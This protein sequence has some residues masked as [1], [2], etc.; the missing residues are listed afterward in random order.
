MGAS[1]LA[2]VL[3]RSVRLDGRDIILLDTG[4][5]DLNSSIYDDWSM[6]ACSVAGEFQSAALFDACTICI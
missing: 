2:A 3:D 4:A 5:A 6:I 1:P